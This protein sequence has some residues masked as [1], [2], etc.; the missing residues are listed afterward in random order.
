MVTGPAPAAGIRVAEGQARIRYVR[1]VGTFTAV[2][3]DRSAH[4]GQPLVSLAH[5]ADGAPRVSIVD[6]KV[7]VLY[8][9]EAVPSANKS[10]E[11]TS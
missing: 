2:L 8:Y 10:I 5:H 7:R 1:G 9:E 4:H 11:S 6:G 3:Y